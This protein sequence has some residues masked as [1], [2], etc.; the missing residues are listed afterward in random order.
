MRTEAD[1]IQNLKDAGCPEE[2]IGSFMNL[3]RSGR[4]KD[5]LRLLQQHRSA[6]L[7]GVHEEERKINCLDYMVYHLE[8]ENGT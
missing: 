5:G 7:D 1:L 6:L 8:K 2:L 4:I 3:Y